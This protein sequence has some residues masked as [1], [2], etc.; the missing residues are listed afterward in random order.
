MQRLLGIVCF[1]KNYRLSYFLNKK[2]DINLSK[3]GKSVEITHKKTSFELPYFYAQKE[4]YHFFLIENRSPISRIFPKFK[5]INYWL[6]ITNDNELDKRDFEKE[7]SSINIILTSLKI[8]DEK[9]FNF[10]SDI[11]YV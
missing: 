2:L 11:L 5:K 10:F 9:V 7:I 4:D 1:E 3:L 8:V 6:Y